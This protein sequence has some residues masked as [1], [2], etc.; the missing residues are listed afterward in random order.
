[1]RIKKDILSAV[2]IL[3]LIGCGGGDSG[4]G[5]SDDPAPT[6]DDVSMVPDPSAAT[7]VFPED[8]TECNTGVIINETQSDVTF[9]WNI[10]Q[11]TDT[12]EVSLTNLNTTTTT[13]TTASTNEATIRLERGTPYEWFVTSSA[14]GT[15][16]TA[17]SPTWRFYNEGPGIQNYAPFPAEAV[18]PSRGAAVDFSSTI[19]LEWTAS[20]V[21]DD[22]ASFEVLFGTDNA[23]LASQGET[24]ST[25]LDVSVT[26]GTIY[27]W[28]VITI[29]EVGN[30]SN[31]EIFEF[32]V[33]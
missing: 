13:T 4:G 28:Q 30:A 16:A 17:T 21:D 6:D 29:D 23:N 3:G 15:N 24:S 27:F 2:L 33:N 8:D 10:S 1:M 7:L 25:N 32:R 31:S 22:I 12:Y 26:A 5:G 14:N 20:D 18:A 9:E 11:N 19:T